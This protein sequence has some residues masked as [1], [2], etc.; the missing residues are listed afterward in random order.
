MLSLNEE[1]K[2]LE[3]RLN[4]NG[5]MKAPAF[6]RFGIRFLLS[7]LLSL[8][9]AIIDH[10]IPAPV[11]FAHKAQLSNATLINFSIVLHEIHI[12]LSKS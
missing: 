8:H 3:L 2:I 5:R 6:R 1:K 11:I 10:H 7:C 9:K 4:Y 12:C